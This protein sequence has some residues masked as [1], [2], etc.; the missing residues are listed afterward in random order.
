[1]PI[2]RHTLESSPAIAPLLPIRSHVLLVRNRL[3]ASPP[4]GVEMVEGLEIE[5]LRRIT[6]LDLAFAKDAEPV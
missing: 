6:G 5:E 4:G 3:S 1:M 2:A